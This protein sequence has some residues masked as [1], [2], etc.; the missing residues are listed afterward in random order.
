MKPEEQLVDCALR[1]WKTY[2]ER[3][4]ALFQ[5]LSEHELQQEIAPGRNRLI[6][7]WGHLAGVSDALFP[8]LGIGP[9][10]HPELDAIFVDAPDH[11]GALPLSGAR[12]KQVAREIDDA[13]WQAFT[14]WTAADWLGRH[15]AVSEDDFAREP[16]RNRF[17]VLLNRTAHMASHFG[18]AQLGIPRS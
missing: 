11:K 4:E 3:V 5:G 17:N 6:Y 2:T 9:R 15:N 1:S 14:G 8:L 16:F 7:L 12:L 18:Q 13:L 10:L